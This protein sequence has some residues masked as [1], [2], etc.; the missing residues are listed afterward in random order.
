MRDN[1]KK[2]CCRFYLKGQIKTIE[3]GNDMLSFKKKVRIEKE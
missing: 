1:I 3:R 2:F